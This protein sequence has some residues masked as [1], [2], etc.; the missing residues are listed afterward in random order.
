MNTSVA[1]DEAIATPAPA[2]RRSGDHWLALL[3]PALVAAAWVLGRG[4]WLRSG[5]DLSY[6]I[7]VAGGSMMLAALLLY[8]LRKYWRALHQAG[9]VKWWFALHM[10]LGLLGPWLILVHSTFR[11]GSLNAGVALLSMV[12]VVASGVI[13]RFL[14]VRVHRGLSGERT[15]LQA[16]QAR[17]GFVEDQARSRLAFAPEVEAGLRAFEQRVLGTPPGLAGAFRQALWLPW[18]AWRERRRCQQRLQAP[19]AALAQ[20]RGWGADELARRRRH[21]CKLVARYLEA[22]VRVAQYSAY[23]RL[24]ALWHVAHLPFVVLLVLS[25]VV[26]VVAVHAY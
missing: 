4:G 11:I 10:V 15:S 16:L 20:R 17:A 18:L 25:A 8:P 3:L 2:R 12:V 21:A 19:L 14:Y 5:D 13:G 22:V 7:A 6:W 9:R 26:H 23:E 1:S 24:F